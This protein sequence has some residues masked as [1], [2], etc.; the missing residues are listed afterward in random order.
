MYKSLV[1]ILVGERVHLKCTMIVYSLL[2]DIVV[3]FY[4]CRKQFYVYHI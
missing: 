4:G 2:H 1:Q 3:P